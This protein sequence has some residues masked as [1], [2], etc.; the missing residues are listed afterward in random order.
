MPVAVVQQ[1]LP[2]AAKT[3]YNSNADTVYRHMLSGANERHFPCENE[4]SDP[5]HFLS[6]I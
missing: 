5:D 3:I 2:P 1:P 6:C 4:K